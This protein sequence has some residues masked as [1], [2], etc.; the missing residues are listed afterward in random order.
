MEEYKRTEDHLINLVLNRN[1][2]T[3]NFALFIG[4]G[5][6]VLSGVKSAIEMIEEW[7]YRLYE[8]SRS[9]KEYDD[10]LSKQEWFNSDKEYSI[11]F[12]KVCDTPAQR[13]TCIENCVKD[14]KPSWGYIYLANLI[15]N[16]FFNV[17]FSTNFDDLLNEAC[18]LYADLKPM[19]CAH[20]SAVANVRLT[21]ARPK[22][23]K[24][25]GD[26][27]YDSIKNTVQETKRLEVNMESKFTQFATEYGLIIVGYGGNDDSIIKILRKLVKAPGYFPNGIYWCIKKG[28]K[29]SPKAEQLL[30]MP[31]IY[32]VEIEGSDELMAYLHKKS[33]L[34]LPNLVKD[35]YKATTDRLNTFLSRVGSKLEGEKKIENPIILEDINQLQS[36]IKDFEEAISRKEE[37]LD[38]LVPYALLGS[39]A[40]YGNEYH[41]AITNFNK[42]YK[43]DKLDEEDMELLS[44]SY[45]YIEDFK[46]AQITIDRMMERYPESPVPYY[47]QADLYHYTGDGDRALTSF[48]TALK[49]ARTNEMKSKIFASISA[50]KLFMTDF[51][52]ALNDAKESLKFSSTQKSVANINRSIALKNLGRTDESKKIL[53]TVLKSERSHY[54]RACVFANLGD[55]EN[56]FKELKLA[57]EEDSAYVIH[58]KTD[59]DFI[60]YR[61]DPRF[62]K[63]VYR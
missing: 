15:A 57:I 24:L 14:A 54:L 46:N 49:Y 5:A 35:P 45:L 29:L 50:I 43:L 52:G 11:L 2:N 44:F 40:Y 18:F 27:L 19:M 61:D 21:S 4:A 30:R 9:K 10:W 34:Q 38:K 28:A 56:L 36:T 51:N 12:E 59:P 6:S 8:Q 37:T 25:H 26:F 1:D 3:P 48:K 47:V 22:I 31:N 63:I 17:I 23:I 33:G 41:D 20:D 58:A 60:D 16:N 53:D 7:R 62:K 55:K 39:F 42:A 32:L 13:R